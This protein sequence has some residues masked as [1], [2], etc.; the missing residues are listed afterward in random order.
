MTQTEITTCITKETLIS[1]KDTLTP[2]TITK[3]A[4]RNNYAKESLHIENA[5]SVSID[6][7]I[8]YQQNNIDGVLNEEGGSC[9]TTTNIL[10]K[11]FNHIEIESCYSSYTTVGIRI[12]DEVDGIQAIADALSIDTSTISP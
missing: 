12:V 10:Y 4:F 2:I 8:C 3:T 11:D 7:F 5:L 6:S 1:I 9:L